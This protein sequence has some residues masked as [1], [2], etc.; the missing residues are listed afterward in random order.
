MADLTLEITGCR[1]DDGHVYAAVYHGPDGFP[2]DPDRAVFTGKSLVRNGRASIE[3][4]D[5][6]SGDYA[7][8]VFHDE[9]DD[10]VMNM[11]FK[12][13]PKEGFGLSG[14]GVGM[15][16]P[17]F[18]DAAFELDGDMKLEVEMNYLL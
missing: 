14:K 11:R 10:G 9:N 6:E 2:D 7:V 18:E 12:V 1:N 13:F 3:V 16:Q 4:P 17:T 5:L 8:G 15:K